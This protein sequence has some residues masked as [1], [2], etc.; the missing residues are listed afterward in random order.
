MAAC[1]DVG[2]CP[3]RTEQLQV[4]ATRIAREEAT[5]FIVIP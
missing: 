1:A 3:E 4:N 5:L 2:H